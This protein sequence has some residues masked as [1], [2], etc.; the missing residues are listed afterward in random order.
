MTGVLVALGGGVGALL[1]WWFSARAR[2]HGATPAG[3]TLLVNVLGSFALG[4]LVSA[5]DP[6]SWLL[7]LLAIGVCGALTTFS[8]HALEVAQAWR[9]H[10]SRHAL[11]NAILS[12]ALALAA[13]GAGTLIGA[14][15]GGR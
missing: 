8:S 13:L 15:L 7:P 10:E 5:L 11:A 3:G 6:T 14:V 2:A 1:R 12:P 4:L 9:D